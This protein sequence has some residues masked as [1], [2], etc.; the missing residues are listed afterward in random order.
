MIKVLQTSALPLGYTATIY[1]SGRRDSNPRPPPW[2]GGVLPLNYFRSWLGY[3]DSNLGMTGPKPVAL[4][5]GYSPIKGRSMGIE[6]T[7]A[8]ATI[9]CVN[10]F[11]TTAIIKMAGVVGI[12][13]TSKVLET[14]VLPLNYT[15]TVKNMT[16]KLKKMVEGGRF[17]LP[18]PKERIYSPPRLA[19]SL[20][21]QK[22]K[23]T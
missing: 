12:E 14:F 18:N 15:P 1:W 6:P 5:L 2:Q 21:L 11:A 16:I 22:N 17:E 20:P 23:K 7:N 10:P 13:P 19:T 8:G 4:P 9:R 3:Q